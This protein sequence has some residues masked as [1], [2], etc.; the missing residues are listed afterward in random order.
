MTGA[1]GSL[2]RSTAGALIAGAGAGRHRG[3]PA[4]AATAL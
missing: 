3:R 2:A 4:S 1:T